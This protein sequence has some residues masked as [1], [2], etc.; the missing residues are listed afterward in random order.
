MVLGIPLDLLDSDPK[1]WNQNEHYNVDGR[2]QQADYFIPYDFL[3][4]NINNS[5]QRILQ[6]TR[7]SMRFI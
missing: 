7:K 3:F 1:L 5:T 4:K 6:N 2:P